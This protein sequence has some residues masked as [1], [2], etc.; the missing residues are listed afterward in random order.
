VVS[1]KLMGL[2]RML[3]SMDWWRWPAA[4]TIL[5]EAMTE[6]TSTRMANKKKQQQQTNV[7]LCCLYFTRGLNHVSDVRHCDVIVFRH[8]FVY[9]VCSCQVIFSFVLHSFHAVVY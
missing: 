4:V 9:D 7:I 6:Y 5:A 3:V 8:F 2:L 1:K